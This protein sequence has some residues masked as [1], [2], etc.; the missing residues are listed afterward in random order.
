MGATPLTLWTINKDVITGKK[1]FL[2]NTT[3]KPIKISNQKPLN[4]IINKLP[5]LNSLEKEGY[6]K[7]TELCCLF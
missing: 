7:L 5:K 6:I 2:K 1:W 3:T 4:E